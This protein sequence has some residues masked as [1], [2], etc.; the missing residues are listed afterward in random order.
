MTLNISETNQRKKKDKNIKKLET[1]II[2]DAQILKQ[3]NKLI[4]LYNFI[5]KKDI[6]QVH[7]AKEDVML[8]VDMFRT[9]QYTKSDFVKLI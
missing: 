2:Y 8:I 5:C 6:I 3:R 7:R 9:L 4:D 1:R